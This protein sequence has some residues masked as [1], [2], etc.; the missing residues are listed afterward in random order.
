MHGHREKA[1]LHRFIQIDVEI[2]RM[3]C[4]RSDGRSDTDRCYFPALCGRQR[5]EY[6]RDQRQEILQSV[7][8][9]MNDYHG[10]SEAWQVLLEGK[11][12]VYGQENIKGGFNNEVQL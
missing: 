11:I 2:E 12:S 6:A 4:T 9:R 10:D 8:L 1:E 3:Q 5:D 7:G